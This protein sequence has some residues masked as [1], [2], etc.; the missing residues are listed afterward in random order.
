M[1]RQGGNRRPQTFYTCPVCSSEFLAGYLSRKFC[2]KVCFYKGRKSDGKKG[3]HYPH[4]QR[5]RIGNCLICGKEYRDVHGSKKH[6]K[7]FCSKVCF[8]THWAKNVRGHLKP[9]TGKF[10]AANKAW[11]GDFVSYDGMHR[12]VRK[13][14]GK[15]SKCEH[16]GT[17]TAKKFEWA[18]VDHLY[19]RDLGDYMRLCTRCHRRYDYENLSTRK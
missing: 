8:Q 16:C 19:R 4:L 13:H 2:S 5:A 14:L 6:P 1:G 18:N 7:K 17:T 9:G 15:P 11:K 12:W 3:K 10:G